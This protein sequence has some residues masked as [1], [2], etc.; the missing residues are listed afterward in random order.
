[1]AKV[2]IIYLVWSDEPKKYLADALAGVAAQT[3]P[4]DK[5]AL[6][7]IYNSH[8]PEE[9]SCL[10]F[11][12]ATVAAS[13]NLPE[14]IILPQSANLGFT[15]GNNAG[16]RWAAD[17]GFDYAFLHN[18]D[19]F[20]RPEAIERLV[21]VMEAD[22]N[23]GQTQALILLHSE[24]ELINSAGNRWHYLGVG[25]C[26][27]FRRPLAG[28]NLPPIKEIGYV[29]G[30]ATLL[31]LDLVNRFGGLNPNFYLY[32]ED[33]EY[34][35]RLK[36]RGFKTT[37]VSNAIFVHRYAFSR[38]PQKYYWLERNRQ[39]VKLLLYRWPTLILLLPL[40]ILYGLALFLTSLFG[41]FTGALLRA[42]GYWLKAGNWSVWLAERKKYQ[43]ER[44]LNDRA[45]LRLA[46]PTIDAGEL[47]A[48]R[49]LVFLAN[50]LFTFY[51]YFLKITVWW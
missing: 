4:K 36:I 33:A 8:R 50:L 45:I 18:A 24:K 27:L 10:E 31:R 14:T 16:L 3:Y 32:H 1:M 48:Q 35:W 38:N 42:W 2:A 19:G 6:V 49:P 7:I 29:S 37:L 30:A 25:Y 20:L 23:I 43:A 5:T 13:D 44:R 22:K 21:A 47:V 28:V 41:G 40:E 51:Y 26:D 34:S 39:A 15:G 12:R 9:P 46:A 11:I 17:N